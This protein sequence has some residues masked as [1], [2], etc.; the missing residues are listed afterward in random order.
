[1]SIRNLPDEST[2]GGSVRPAGAR[3]STRR[4]SPTSTHASALGSGFLGIGL[5]IIA[6]LQ[7]MLGI[8]LFM[9]R[10]AEYPSL[11]PVIGAWLLLMVTFFGLSITIS[12]TGERLPDW[13]YFFFLTALAAV[14]WLD[15]IAIAPSTM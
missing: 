15:F 10:A 3:S 6:A 5:A 8:A 11:L 4:G 7:S 13:L 12:A 9:S 2:L 1:M 14:V